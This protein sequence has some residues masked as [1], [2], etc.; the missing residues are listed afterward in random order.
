MLFFK[1]KLSVKFKGHKLM[2]FKVLRY[3]SSGVDLGFFFFINVKPDV[4][5]YRLQVLLSV[6]FQTLQKTASDLRYLVELSYEQLFIDFRKTLKYEYYW[7][8][9]VATSAGFVV[10]QVME[11]NEAGGETA[12]NTFT[13]L[14]IK[15][16][17]L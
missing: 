1:D 6:Y 17:K 8:L 16:R 11:R 13:I 14:I 5:Q 4:R 2:N 15:F 7:G 10:L 3:C 9:T 12:T